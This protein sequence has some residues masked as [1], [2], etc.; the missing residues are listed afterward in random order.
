MCCLGEYFFIQMT[1]WYITENKKGDLHS[2]DEICL[3]CNVICVTSFKGGLCC[4][5]EAV[6]LPSTSYRT[7]C[8]L[9]SPQPHW[10]RAS[11]RKIQRCSTLGTHHN[12][13]FHSA[14][15]TTGVDKINHPKSPNPEM[16][17]D[18]SCCQ[19]SEWL[20]PLAPRPCQQVHLLVP[21]ASGPVGKRDLSCRR[22]TDS[23]L[24]SVAYV[25][26]QYSIEKPPS[27]C[28]VFALYVCVYV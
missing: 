27:T 15:L 13:F 25:T 23:R 22:E 12:F 3:K 4:V 9:T 8:W 11:I 10:T 1:Y 20:P 17:S 24:Y 19:S 26:P 6:P 14:V 28:F 18:F 2:S 16:P 7:Q 5:L 21:S